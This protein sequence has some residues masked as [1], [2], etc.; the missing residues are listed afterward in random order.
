MLFL[1][2]SKICTFKYVY[3]R[4][5]HFRV[6]WCH[7]WACISSR[8]GILM[9]WSWTFWSRDAIDHVTIRFAIA[10]VKR[11]NKYN[12]LFH[13]SVPLEASLSL[14]AFEI[15]APKAS[16]HIWVTTL[17]FQRHVRSSIA[18]SFDSA[19]AIFYY[20]P[21]GTGIL[22]STVFE[23]FAS[24]SRPWVSGSRDVTGHVTIRYLRCH[25]I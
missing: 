12:M 2:M 4:P 23:I 8:I 13:V 3:G 7:N 22:Y 1:M 6:T 19:Y 11:I 14:W 9:P 10:Y 18:W 20:C 16:K 17:T 5:W 15:F 25:F 24:G 21:T